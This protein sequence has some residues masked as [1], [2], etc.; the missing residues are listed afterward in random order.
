MSAARRSIERACGAASASEF[1]PL[2]GTATIDGV[3]FFDFNNG[4]RGVAPNAIEL[5]PGLRLQTGS[6]RAR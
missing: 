4:Q 6:C 1:T 5:H 2:Q 3:G